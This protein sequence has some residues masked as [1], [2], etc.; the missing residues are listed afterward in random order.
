MV[1]ASGATKS[2]GDVVAVSDVSF[3][4][5]AGVTAILG[6]NG[7]GKSTLFRL[8]CGL[9][10]PSRGSVT[11]LGENA[12][13]NRDVRGRIGLAPQQD[14]LFDRLSA[15]DFVTF[16]ALT[17][18]VADAER[19]AR[20]ALADV[21]LSADDPKPVG[22]FSKGMRQRAKL[23]AALVNDPDVLVLDEPLTGLD[24]VQRQRMIVLFHELPI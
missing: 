20:Q 23:A 18:G 16:T 22:S 12:R 10:P 17:H 4:I 14:A 13:T 8:L 7:A 6:P 1:A 9:T 5:G 19:V 11:I 21:E 15:H 3:E 24:P 2:F